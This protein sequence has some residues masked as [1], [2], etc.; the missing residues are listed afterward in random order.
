MNQEVLSWA[1][2][3]AP[4]MT[5]I[6]R[7]IHANPELSSKEF[8]TA[9]L[10]RRELTDM[11]IPWRAV[12]TGTIADISGNADGPAI[13][14]RAD[15]DALPMQEETGLPYASHNSG[16]MHACGHDSHTAMLLGAARILQ[17][18]ASRLKHPV[19]LI[20]QPAE[21]NGGGSAR[22]IAGGALENASQVFC[23]HVLPGTPVGQLTVRPG[24]IHAASDG[25]R[26][27]VHGTSAH[28][29]APH[30][31][32]DAIVI[33]SHM[34]LALQ[35]L[36]SRETSAWEQ[37][38]FSIGAFHGGKA[39]NV[40]CDQVVMDATLRT[41]NED[42]RAELHRRICEVCEGTAAMLRG[43]AQVEFVQQYCSCYNNPEL[44][45]ETIRNARALLGEKQVVLLD[46]PAM[47]SEDFGAYEQLVPG[48]KLFIGTG[49]P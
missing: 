11:G 22:M 26:I 13:A 14:L 24:Y 9:A 36:I 30:K 16:V 42:V 33:A 49:F 7:E 41:L 32:V 27:T 38:V 20:F 12:E 47:E 3:Q 31:G 21:E 17:T 23:L 29:S 48:V 34:V 37:A 18:H 43:S 44:T 28:G 39:R 2:E 46:R 19:R 6:R 1:Q 35:E 4:W 25:I 10:I 5:A 15:I 45:E 40:I 8:E